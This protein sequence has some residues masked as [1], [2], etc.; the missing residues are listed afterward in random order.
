MI[1]VA[2]LG[3]ALAIAYFSWFRDSSLVA[4]EHVE[5]E[6]VAS[7]DKQKIVAELTHAARQMTTL[8]VKTDRLTAAVR[9]SASVASLT[10]DPSFPH[11]LTIHVIQRQPALVAHHG[12]QQEPVATDGSVLP[13][14]EVPKSLPQLEVASLPASGR[15]SGEALAEALT[16]GAAPAPLRPLIDGTTRSSEFGITVTMHGGIELKFGTASDL[17]AK[18]AAVAAILADPSVG[19]LTYVDVRAPQRPAVGGTSAPSA[20]TIPV[21]PTTTAPAAPT[22]VP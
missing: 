5:V 8:H 7:S 6:G 11:G 1:V 17:E 13:G 10:A 22:A 9:D 16:I 3:A 4:V 20:A 2:A 19:S 15:L 14:I 12:D 18:W 21:T